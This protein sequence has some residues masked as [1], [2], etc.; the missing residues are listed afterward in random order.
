MLVGDAFELIRRLPDACVDLTITSPP[1]FQQRRYT[2]L[3]KEL[4]REA[5]VE[6]YLERMLWLFDECLRVTKPEGSIVF[7]L[8]DK[9]SKSGLLLIPWRFAVA[10]RQKATLLNEVTWVKA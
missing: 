6:T 2:N 7:N 1:Y 4:G 3:P 9:Y 10:A 8:G 5:D